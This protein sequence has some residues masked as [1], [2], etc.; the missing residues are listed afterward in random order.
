LHGLVP[1]TPFVAVWQPLKRLGI[2]QQ[3]ATRTETSPPATSVEE[4]SALDHTAQA[5]P[6]RTPLLT[7]RWE[8]P[9]AYRRDATG[10]DEAKH[11]GSRE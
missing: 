1:M 10:N 4:L 5:S 3:G 2:G 11:R 6:G 7:Q 9:A 8:T